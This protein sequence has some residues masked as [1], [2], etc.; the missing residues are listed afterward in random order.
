MSLYSFFKRTVLYIFNS[1]EAAHKQSVN[2]LGAGADLKTC[3][4]GGAH[5]WSRGDCVF[6]FG[7]QFGGAAVIP[8]PPQVILLTV[9]FVTQCSSLGISVS[10]FAYSGQ[11]PN[12]ICNL[13]VEGLCELEYF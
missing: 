8:I 6:V 9:D 12:G 3:P 2:L 11:F 5:K 7:K 13:E 10:Q 4:R 1:L